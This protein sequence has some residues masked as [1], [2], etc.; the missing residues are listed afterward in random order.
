VWV[1]RSTDDGKTF[2]DET[3]AWDRPTGACGCCYVGASAAPG[4]KLFILY[5]AAESAIE[6]DMFLLTSNDGGKTFRGAEVDGWRTST[7]PMSTASLAATKQGVMAGW[8]TEGK[9][10]FGSIDATSAGIN[11]RFPAP[12]NKPRAKVSGRRRRTRAARRSAP[13]PK[14]WRGSAAGRRR[15]R[16]TTP[17]AS[18]RENP[19]GPTGV[20][21]DGTVAAFARDDGTFV[22]MY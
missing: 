17:T 9:V 12:G 15:G 4:G 19:A 7:C 2:A 8:E 20:P 3:M 5:R 22:V 18:R 14:A 1:A 21:A 16:S 6:R 11:E 10:I 13:G